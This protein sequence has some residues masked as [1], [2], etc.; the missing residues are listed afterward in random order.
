MK[1]L[2][3]PF[4][5]HFTYC[6]RIENGQTTALYRGKDFEKKSLLLRGRERQTGGRDHFLKRQIE[7][8]PN[9]KAF[10]PDLTACAGTGNILL[11]V[12]ARGREVNEPGFGSLRSFPH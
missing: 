7:M 9:L 2:R 6:L 10:D 1:A 4:S 5:F 12:F 3:L 11:L 8:L